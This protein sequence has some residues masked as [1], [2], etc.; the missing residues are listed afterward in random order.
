MD[1]FQSKRGDRY[2]LT[3]KDLNILDMQIL[4]TARR[5]AENGGS[6]AEHGRQTLAFWGEY[7][8]A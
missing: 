6:L 8:K 7:D 4:P 1:D 3:P 5:W 2:A